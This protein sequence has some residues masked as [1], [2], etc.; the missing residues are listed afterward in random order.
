MTRWPFRKT[1]R[2][3]KRAKRTDTVQGQWIMEG[4]GW[5]LMF[6]RETFRSNLLPTKPRLR[7]LEVRKSF[8]F[9]RLRISPNL[10]DVIF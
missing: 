2:Q 4:V 5:R 8:T 6:E 9:T 10:T 1:S 3:T 7:M